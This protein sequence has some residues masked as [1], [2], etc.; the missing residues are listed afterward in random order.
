MSGAYAHITL[1]NQCRPLMR[2]YKISNATGYAVSTFLGYTEL[3]AISPDYPYLGGE[4]PWADLFHHERTAEFFRNGVA[5]IQAQKDGE[6]RQKL[7]AWLFGYA[8]HVAADVTIH[9]IVNAIVGPYEDNKSAHRECE[10][11]QDSHVFQRLNVD[12]DTGATSHLTA[13]IA[14]CSHPQDPNRLDPMI[15]GPWLE[16]IRKT[17]PEKVTAGAP[18]LDKWHAGF[19]RMMT[20]LRKVNGLLPFARHLSA[21]LKVNYPRPGTSDSR[22]LK[23]L[24]TP[25]GTPIDYDPLFDRATANAMALWEVLDG[26]LSGSD[27]QPLKALQSWNLDTGLNLSTRKSV[28]WEAKP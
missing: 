27:P 2:R 13:T 26:T 22:F 5:Q 10:M 7:T 23:G 25:L 16:I 1:A 28:Y 9:P 19:Q 8:A 6:A 21:D 18:S 17:Y 11:H 3:G 12:P 24:P 20:V 14:A 4:A 15:A